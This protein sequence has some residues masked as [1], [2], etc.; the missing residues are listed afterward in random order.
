MFKYRWEHTYKERQV[1]AAMAIG[2]IRSGSRVFV[3]SGCG[4]P[5]VLIDAM[6]GMAKR[7]SDIEIIQGRTLGVL[8]SAHQSYQ[9]SFRHHTFHIGP[10]IQEAVQQG[11]ADYTPVRTSQ[12]PELFASRRIPIDV[13][14]F[15]LT[16]P[17][18]HG[19]C[20]MGITVGITK[21]AF[22]H[23][24]YR[25]AQ[26][27]PHMPWTY[28]NTLVHVSEVDAFVLADTPL[29]ET[30]VPEIDEISEKIAIRCT[31]H[32]ENGATLRLGYNAISAA[33]ARRLIQEDRKDIGI[34]SEHFS[35]FMMD[36]MLAGVATNTRKGLYNG[37]SV[38][39][40]CFGSRKLYD[41]VDNNPQ[42]EIRSVAEV[43][44]PARIAMNERMVAI[45]RVAQVDLTGQVADESTGI[46]YYGGFGGRADFMRG[47]AASRRGK[48]IVA[49]PSTSPDGTNSN[50]KMFLDPGAGV[51]SNR[52]DACYV[53]T[54]W[55]SALLQ[56]RPIRER[57]IALI[58]I[59]HPRFRNELMAAAKEHRYVHQ[60][61]LLPPPNSTVYPDHMEVAADFR[62][63]LKVS[64]RPVKPSDERMVQAFV[65]GLEERSIYYR[66]HGKMQTMHH[67]RIQH[68]VNVD[69]HETMTL[70]GLL[71]D[72]TE[73]EEMVAMGQYL[74][75]PESNRAEV[76]FI[77]AD[78]YQNLGIGTWIL[79][80]LIRYARE[81]GIEGFF[82]E[83][84]RQNRQMLK[85]FQKSGLPTKTTYEGST[86]L[87]EFDL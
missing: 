1:S 60:D 83:V 40:R 76:A 44:D 55:G 67:N 10:S 61:Q 68:F 81:R 4:R 77:T 63:G 56:G 85:V 51:I 13:V 39:C 62:N 30:T 16:P 46:N 48:F 22:E 54:E 38:A 80:A 75:Y 32:I 82:A 8:P 78:E 2:K 21:H 35:D 86:C 43:N 70:I 49:L 34:H 53:I 23:A 19:Y 45:T 36:M 66:F 5:Q 25:I 73:G 50:I 57:A 28:G 12:V 37:K 9:S 6:T 15:Q 59:A 24:H 47:A 29:P 65:Y 17:N 84:L 72:S 52:A 26:V 14:L 58:N 42:V 31:R 11:R 79:Q 20:S 7:F 69:Y 41:F 33:I 87:V 71:G 3:G 27:N 64:F 74:R 18:I